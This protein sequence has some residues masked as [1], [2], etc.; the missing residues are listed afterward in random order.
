MSAIFLSHSSRDD[1]LATSLEGWLKKYGFDDIFV[2]HSDIRSGD[3]WTDALRRAKG[4]CRVVLCLVT[5]H[6]LS[7][8]ECYSEF[9]AA[10]YAGR[11]VIPILALDT[12]AL[13]EKQGERL[14]R[15]LSE[16]QGANVL[17][18]IGPEG[19]DLDRF[20]EIT[21]PLK[22]G[23]RAA[24]ALAKLGL[25]PYAF[26]IDQK[27]RP[28]P[29]PGLQSFGDTD[30][31][32]AVFF[33]RSGDIARCL[34]DLREMRA[35]GDR[36][37]YAILGA[38]GS[39]KSSLLK[40]GLLPRLRREPAWL[41]LRAFRPGVDPL[42]NFAHAI[43]QTADDLGV[44]V[45]AGSIRDGLLS[46]W[47]E[48]RDLRAALDG[49]MA[50]LKTA[51]GRTEA[52][53]LIALDQGEE[54]VRAEG[55]GADA[56]A[57][58]LKAAL[59]EMHDG[60]PAPYAV[61]Y[62]LRSDCLP[63]L[64]ACPRLKGLDVRPQNIRMLPRYSFDTAI[65]QPAARYGV[66]FEPSLVEALMDDIGDQDALPIL[67]FALQRLW[68]QYE[69]ERRIRKTNY[70]SIGKL[71]GLIEDAAERALRGI[72][73]MGPQEPIDRNIPDSKDQQAS[74]IFL[75]A[76][77]QVNERG[78]AIRRLARLADFD[79]VAKQLLNAFD[80]WRLIVRSGDGVEV[81]HDALF[82]EWPR[83]RIWLVPEKARLEA[84]HGV[85]SAAASWDAKGRRADGLIHRGGPLIA[86]LALDK[87]P[88]YRIQLDRKPEVR[89]YLD[90]CRKARRK[91][92]VAT[93]A[94]VAAALCAPLV[95]VQIWNGLEALKRRA[96]VEA[97]DNYVPQSPVL[98][99]GMK[100]STLPAGAAFRD[101]PECPEMVVVPAGSFVMGSPPQE[102]FHEKDE[103]P[104][105]RVT[106]GKFAIGKFDVT[107]NEWHIC[108]VEGGCRENQNPSDQGWGKG[109]RP[110]IGISWTDAQQFVSW[111]SRRTG[112]R[113][114]LPS[115]A[116][117][118]YATRATATT[119]FW[120]GTSI[121]TDQANFNSGPQRTYP[122][123]SYPPNKFGLFDMVG[124]VWQW[125]E[126]CY[127]PDYVD[128]PTGGSA[129][130]RASCL[131]RGLRGGSWIDLPRYLRS[132]QRYK[133]LF[134]VTGDS[135]GFRIARA[136]SA[137][138][139]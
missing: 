37:A 101:C 5:R 17:K 81:A 73:P 61:T 123:G 104:L 39:G 47:S 84:L 138:P 113:Y 45:A 69:Q 10:W 107:F 22:A 82:R 80:R 90:A 111:L 83:F 78:A 14:R 44:H 65:E 29:F 119:P 94:V 16:D 3:K 131:Q 126:D 108:V 86:A 128:A 50:P 130:K 66:E 64:D 42:L 40:A 93:C 25:D 26:E 133:L 48:A 122:V 7:S 88:D 46:A 30:A 67:A 109:R 116:E 6:W 134:S 56:L 136:V 85:E 59:A 15:L 139:G 11:R 34:E 63:D 55:S 54:L 21:E 31:D 62:T 27:I 58:Y 100:A 124:N 137:H 60:E 132:A 20:P 127:V 114:R 74:R 32:A 96:A 95:V 12:A 121:G 77:A 76:L 118:E 135:M 41:A 38:S 52:T 70:E 92:A 129:S 72:D 87:V 33:G 8:D 53:V 49:V 23:L 89:A 106:L 57:A 99:K 117:W 105:H 79:D 24:G 71:S 97:A 115:E 102:P 125:V 110:V 51:A 112:R 91:R 98:T 13:E 68:C 9:L 19:F 18:A 1:V 36:R 4:S 120:T 2:D 75:P 43:A 103:W 28:H 35:T